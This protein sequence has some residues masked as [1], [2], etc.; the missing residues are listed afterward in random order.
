[1][2]KPWR[3]LLLSLVAGAC[4]SPTRA[5]SCTPYDVAIAAE[6]ASLAAPTSGPQPEPDSSA[7]TTDLGSV[8]AT[9]T[10]PGHVEI[11][12]DVSE[13]MR[14]ARASVGALVESLD[15]RVLPRAGARGAVAHYLV[16]ATLVPKPN[17]LGATAMNAPWT[18][19]H[20]V[21]RQAGTD[22]AAAVVDAAIIVSDLDMEV[23]PEL[24]LSGAPVCPGAASTTSKRAGAYFGTCFESGLD[25]SGVGRLHDLMA[26]VV[27]VPTST[28]QIYVLVVGT[29]IELVA[30]ILSQTSEVLNLGADHTTTIVDTR[31][32]DRSAAPVCSYGEGSGLETEVDAGNSCKLSCRSGAANIHCSTGWTGSTSA[33]IGFGDPTW[34]LDVLSAGK[35][36]VD[37]DERQRAVIRTSTLTDL[38]L[39]LGCGSGLPGGGQDLRVRASVQAPWQL[40]TELPDG[41]PDTAKEL[42]D[43]LA[44]SIV[45][46]L[47]PATAGYE[48][49]LYGG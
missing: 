39:Q 44:R 36:M 3:W 18:A 25:A 45:T 31:L 2:K 42:L 47:E 6:A 9:P 29:N 17:A 35:P 7:G 33:M 38:E 46:R 5:G 4:R 15:S 13:S 26:G 11:F 28:G 27:R 37:G 49:G 14:P 12:W 30:S 34:S 43:S 10:G 1:M 24:R 22:L 48:L 41:T 40:N 32:R 16:G 8:P 23:P 20:D 21:A 19:L